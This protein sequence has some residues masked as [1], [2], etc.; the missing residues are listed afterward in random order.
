MCIQWKY[1]G[2]WHSATLFTGYVNYTFASQK[3]LP[4]IDHHQ[5]AYY[6]TKK[7]TPEFAMPDKQ[8]VDTNS[9]DLDV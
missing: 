9:R 2:L 7:T 8:V 3:P 5:N 6:T 4:V 1:V